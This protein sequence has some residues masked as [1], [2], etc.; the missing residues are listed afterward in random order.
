LK[1][2]IN[3][4]ADPELRELLSDPDPA[5]QVEIFTKF[6]LLLKIKTD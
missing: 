2:D 4:I 3:G 6:S 1:Y 5:T